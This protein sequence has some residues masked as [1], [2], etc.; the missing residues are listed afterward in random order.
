[1]PEVED[2]DRIEAF[3]AVRLFVQ[4]AR[5]VEPALVPSVEAAAIVDIC[6]Q[7]EGLPLALELA[8]AW[9]RVLSC[10][11]IAAEL[12]HGTELLHAGTRRIRPATRASTSCSTN[13][14]GC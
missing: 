12:R 8:A 13:R 10:D 1:M 4:A 2:E 14:G 9:T 7:V 6:R 11:A 5:R 3:D